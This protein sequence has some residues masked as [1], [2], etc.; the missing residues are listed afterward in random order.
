M[1]GEGATITEAVDCLMR[2]LNEHMIHD[3]R[4]T[5][6]QTYA[7]AEGITFDGLI[8]IK[9]RSLQAWR[10]DPARYVRT[11]KPAQLTIVPSKKEPNNE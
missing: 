3:W 8:K 11:S 1:R 9:P 6:A 2:R 4:E 5:I 7:M 10:L